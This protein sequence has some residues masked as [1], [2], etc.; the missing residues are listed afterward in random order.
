MASQR[1]IQSLPDG[2]DLYVNIGDASQSRGVPRKCCLK[3][4]NC[5]A[6]HV[7]V[8]YAIHVDV[9]DPS[10]HGTPLELLLHDST[11]GPKK[12]ARNVRNYKINMGTNIHYLLVIGRHFA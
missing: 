10:K 3:K 5:Y 4:D 8:N 12:W 1:S 2:V 9:N 6:L 7:N 11:L